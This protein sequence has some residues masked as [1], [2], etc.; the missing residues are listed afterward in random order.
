M[1]CVSSIQDDSGVPQTTCRELFQSLRG[2][3]GRPVLLLDLR[4]KRFFGASHI[5]GALHISPAAGVLA[6]QLPNIILRIN[7]IAGVPDVQTLSDAGKTG[8][9]VLCVGI[10][11][12][13]F[14]GPGAMVR[15][16]RAE[17]IDAKF[18]SK[19][20]MD[21]WR[22]HKLPLI[23]P[24]S[25][26]RR[27]RPAQQTGAPGNWERDDF[28]FQDQITSHDSGAYWR[29]FGGG[30]DPRSVAVGVDCD[31]GVW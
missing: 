16:M 17:G 24:S 22:A 19:G 1:G 18:V 5:H 12:S 4:L 13:E 29:E 3:T 8:V 14:L 7:A 15:A 23:R 6:K 21:E 9:D 30:D 20:G 25:P 10:A 28:N 31:N 11:N 2:Q 27:T 26:A